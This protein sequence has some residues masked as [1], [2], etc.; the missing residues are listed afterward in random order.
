[1]CVF[2]EAKRNGSIVRPGN[3][4]RHDVSTLR[5]GGCCVAV[6][7]HETGRGALS[8][9]CSPRVGK[10]FFSTV[11]SNADINWEISPR[12]KDNL[13]PGTEDEALANLGFGPFTCQVSFW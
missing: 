2:S 11:L 13:V 6:V 9:L 7:V 10:N 12:R 5:Y 3:W 4:S 8:K 1:M